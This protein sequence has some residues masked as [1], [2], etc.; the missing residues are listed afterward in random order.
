MIL[1]YT[2]RITKRIG[3]IFKLYFDQI[4]ATN[5]EMTSNMETFRSF[6]GAKI[7]YSKEHAEGCLHFFP[8]ELLFKTGIE[9]Q[10][11]SVFTY[12]GIK[13]FYPVHD[14]TSV[15]PFDP[16]AAAFYLVTRYEEY[17]PYKKDRFGRFDAIESF[18]AKNDF[19]QKPLINIWAYQI[20]DLLK[21]KFPGL[22]F[23]KR[24][25]RFRPTLDI[26]S[27]YAFLHK[28]VVRN[29][30]ATGRNIFNLDFKEIKE[31][32]RVLVGRQEDPFDTY[33]FQLSLQKE[34]HL[35]PIYFILMADY[36]EFDKNLPVNNAN[37]QRLIK[38]L[39]DYAEVGI[40][41]SFGAN[42]SF[43]RLNTE[44]NR[45]SG[46]LNREITKSRQH[47]LRLN[48]P[49][50][51]RNLIQADITDDYTMGYASLP[52]FR[53]GICDT[54]YF[55]DL[56]LET[57][58]MLR[59]HPFAVMDGT[60]K[61]YVQKEP[62]ESLEIIREIIDEVKAVDGTFISLWHNESLNDL[63]RWEGWQALYVEM[64]RYAVG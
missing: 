29:V 23:R 5:Y 26:D 13:A 2:P 49:V 48:F 31:R 47:F 51:Y 53:A 59:V 1:V 43:Q 12:N 63:K 60:L 50:T 17:L 15:F 27:A 24:Q 55:Y 10:E 32:F 62:A 54:Y 4:L 41:P 18:S 61:D 45:L 58:T 22:R 6:H 64:I 34:F 42:T 52:G 28:G 57:E 38:S 36:G 56:D 40:H 46:I 14:H 16:F 3:Y 11:L 37:F 7:N 20:R 33:D 35:H 19:L 21:E 25:F 44:V 8:A 9:G 39:A 30:A